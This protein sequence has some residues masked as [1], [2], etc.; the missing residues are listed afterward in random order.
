MQTPTDVFNKWAALPEWEKHYRRFYATAPQSA[1]KAL[2]I[3]FLMTAILSWPF[4]GWKR[5]EN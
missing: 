1:Y 3:A 4:R 2:R 5:R